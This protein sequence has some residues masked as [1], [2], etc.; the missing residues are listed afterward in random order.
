MNSSLISKLTKP[1]LLFRIW[2]KIR[3][4]FFLDQ[5]IVLVAPCTGYESLSWADFRPFIPPPDRFWADP[6]VWFHD[7]R[8]YVFIE[9]VPYTTHRGHIVCLTLDEKMNILSNQIV[10]EQPYH[11][12][13]PFLF[14]H[15]GQL[16][17]IPETAENNRIELY[18]C[19][20]FPDRWEFSKA[21]INNVY[22]VDSTLLKTKNK[23]WL[24][25][26]VK[27]KGGSSWD[28][29][30]LYYAD[31]PLSSQW[32]PH[33]L[34]PIVKDIHSARP[35]GRIFSHNGNLI[36][37]SQ[38]CSARYGYATN[39]NHIV[40]LTETDYAEICELTF[41]PPDKSEILATHTYNTAAGL[42]AIDAIQRKRK[43]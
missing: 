27:E 6:F 9:E 19:T 36:R 16:F 8:H 12:S 38:D 41:K 29:L 1:H 17:M 7:N 26:N 31:H 28:M 3:S 22:A 14:E 43:F 39:F 35:A 40:T 18:R 21:I 33:P 34:N 13:Y 11:L 15:E 4:Y 24:F 37:P 5:W 32:T 2:K 20:H 23:W 42:T 25:A 30:Y 10:L